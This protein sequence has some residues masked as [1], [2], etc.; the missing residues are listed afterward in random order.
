[1]FNYG[2]LLIFLFGLAGLAFFLIV[3][4]SKN[5]RKQQEAILNLERRLSDLMAIQLKEIRDNV[6]LSS[7]E[8]NKQIRSFTEETVGLKEGIKRLGEQVWEV[9]SFQEIFKA[10]KT[11]G[12][13]GELS[14]EHILSQRYPDSLYQRECLFES[15]ERVDAILKLPN[16]KF[17]PIDA[18]FPLNRYSEMVEAREEEKPALRK[19]FSEAVK[20]KILEISQKYILPGEG[21]TDFAI[22]Y[23]PAEAVYYEILNNL[24]E[25]DLFAFA[26]SKK[27]ILASPNTIYLTFWTIEHWINDTKIFKETQAIVRRLAKIQTDAERLDDDFRKLGSNLRNAQSAYDDSEK[28]LTMFQE[29]V[30]KVIESGETKKLTDADS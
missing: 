6:N 13:W 3:K 20:A 29:K 5:D 16:G 14:L 26:W 21:T 27:I 15:G 11:R 19:L 18:K 7:G 12:Q 17:L 2:F 28:R 25:I 24:K 10:P 30:E 1:M 9:S 23:I 4:D 22:M 8:M